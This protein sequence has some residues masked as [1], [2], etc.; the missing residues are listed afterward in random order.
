MKTLKCIIVDDEA[1]ARQVVRTYLED[2][3][4]YEIIAECK[5]AIEA[6]NILSSK[7]I[8]LMFLDINMPKLSGLVF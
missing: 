1:L 2:L 7:D 4:E 3:P 8:D 6:M 5:N